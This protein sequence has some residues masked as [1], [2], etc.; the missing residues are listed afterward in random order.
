MLSEFTVADILPQYST[1]VAINRDHLVVGFDRETIAANVEHVRAFRGSNEAMCEH[2]GITLKP[3][4]NISAARNKL[5]G[6]SDVA[7]FIEAIEYR[8]FDKRWIFF[9]PTLVW[10]TAPITS[11]NV[12]GRQDNRVLICLG[13]NRA[14]TTNGHWVSTTLADKAVVSCA[15]M[16]PASLF[17]HDPEG[18][19]T[20]DGGAPRPNL[21]PDFLRMLAGAISAPQMGPYQ[22][23][24]DVLPEDIFDF[25]YAVLYSPDTALATLHSLRR[26]S[27]CSAAW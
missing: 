15:T 13:K 24:R 11:R 21:S 16:R 7:H 18:G 4:W 10:Q 8:P 22:L 6:L 5:Q 23:P 12:V 20:L 9:H 17:L 3:G 2:F 1:L 19:L 26:L 27:S 25:I 14:E